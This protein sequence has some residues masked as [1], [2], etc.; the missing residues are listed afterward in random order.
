MLSH[1]LASCY[2]CCPATLALLFNDSVV[3][4]KLVTSYNALALTTQC[5][6]EQ[7]GLDNIELIV[8]GVRYVGC[9]LEDVT[10]SLRAL[11]PTSATT[12]RFWTGPIAGLHAVII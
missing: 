12:E 7:I 9:A 8:G 4:L 2:C 3:E 10:L 1:H 6:D 5:K 11:P